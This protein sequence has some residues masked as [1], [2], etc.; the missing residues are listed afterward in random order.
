MNLLRL[1]FD[2]LHCALLALVILF[3]VYIFRS[4]REGAS[5]I[6]YHPMT[7]TE[8]TRAN[9]NEKNW[10]HKEEQHHSGP[11]GLRTVTVPGSWSAVR[12]EFS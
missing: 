11:A 7:S 3:A 6:G 10:F 12:T 5:G 2:T 8:I 1:K 9:Q 4:F